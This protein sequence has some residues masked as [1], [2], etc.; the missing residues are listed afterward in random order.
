MEKMNHVVD[1]VEHILKNTTNIVVDAD[2]KLIGEN[3]MKD[4][5]KVYVVASPDMAKEI[6]KTTLD[7]ALIICTFMKPNTVVVVKSE[8][9]EKMIDDGVW[10]E[11]CSD[12]T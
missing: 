11:R 1:H 10:F 2:R 9:F 8:D 6:S 3:N 4:N 7:D 5:E 12:G